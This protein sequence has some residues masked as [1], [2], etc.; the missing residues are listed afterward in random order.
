MG[1]SRM[2]P[3][4][5]EF[6]FY[7]RL[8]WSLLALHQ[9]RDHSLEYEPMFS[10]EI[11]HRSAHLQTRLGYSSNQRKTNARVSFII[12]SS[13]TLTAFVI[14]PI[15][16]FIC[17]RPFLYRMPPP[18]LIAVC[19][20]INCWN[21]DALYSLSLSINDLHSKDFRTKGFMH[22]SLLYQQLISQMC[23]LMQV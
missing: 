3:G 4:I 20:V 22:R 15:R 12:D 6:N 14:N 23:S 8:M 10:Q 2:L 11:G 17:T 13:N 1:R 21:F 18:Q 7:K 19:Q 5:F 9:T 16:S